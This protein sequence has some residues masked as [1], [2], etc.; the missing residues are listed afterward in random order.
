MLSALA[1][2]LVLGGF[3]FCTVPSTRKNEYAGLSP[4]VMFREHEGL[5]LVLDVE[6][7]DKACLD[8]SAVLLYITV[9]VEH[10]LDSV[11]L[12]ARVSPQLAKRGISASVIA[13]YYHD[14][15]FLPARRVEEAVSA[16]WQLGAQCIN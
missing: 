11:G 14:P 13:A 3:V 2:R 16:L 15:I 5:T 9:G 10:A 7:A 1:S 8:N 6:S 4:L 12:T